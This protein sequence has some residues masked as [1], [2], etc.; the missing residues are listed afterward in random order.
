MRDK[1]S[2]T[3]PIPNGFQSTDI[4]LIPSDWSVK[5]LEE[6]ALIHSGGTPS[7]GQPEYWNGD[8]L[9]CTPTDITALN[10]SKYIENTNRKISAKGLSS[11]SAELIPVNSVIMTSRATIGECAINLKPVA[12]NQGFKNFVPFD[13]VNTEFL[14]YLL[15]TKKYDFIRLCG[16]STFLEIGKGQLKGFEVQWP[17]DTAEQSAIAGVISDVDSLILNLEKLI[18]KKRVIKQGAMQELLTGKRRLR[19][20]SGKWSTTTL[21]NAT[22][23]LDNLRVPLNAKQRSQMRGDIP[24]CGANGVLDYVNDY[25]IDDDII[26]IAEDGGYFDEYARRP[27][28]YRMI[29]KCWVNN[30]AHILK[31]KPEFSQGF[32]FYSLQHKNILQFLASGTRAKLNKSEMYKIEIAIPPEEREQEAISSLLDDMVG[33]I[34]SLE[35]KLKKTRLLKHGMM[36]SLLTGKIRLLSK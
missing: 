23:C 34:S 14:Y 18:A 21:N 32:V 10:G 26:L 8:I 31:A 3:K 12:T 13:D 6:L 4:G 19:G 16:G 7:T 20:F 28:A 30:H 5:R 15:K 25:V 29:G 24:Y 1:V 22:D 17:S 11:S 27:I 33:D 9:W 35:T 36:Q 2:K